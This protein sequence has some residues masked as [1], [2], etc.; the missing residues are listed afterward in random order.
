MK[1]EVG[2]L[3]QRHRISNWEHLR[4]EH[5]ARVTEMMGCAASPCASAATSSAR[6]RRTRLEPQHAAG[7]VRGEAPSA[8]A[9][10]AFSRCRPRSG[11]WEA[12]RSERVTQRVGP[13][14]KA[15]PS[16]SKGSLVC[17]ILSGDPGPEGG[18]KVPQADVD[19]PRKPPGEKGC[20]RSRSR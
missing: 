8:N 13:T 14:I 17:P 2:F 19:K 7:A 6:C 11:D 20:H 15:Q 18:E 4:G 3:Q 10:W 16:R 9:E 1:D 12:Q 5:R